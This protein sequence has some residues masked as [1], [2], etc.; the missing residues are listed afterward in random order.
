MPRFSVG[1]H[2]ASS[3]FAPVRKII[4]IDMDAFYAS[5]E[6]RDHPD[7]QGKAIA[8]GGGGRRG[9]ITTASYE[10]RK[11]GVRS[12]MPGFKAK[13]LCPHLIFVPLRFDAYKEASQQIR[14]VFYQYT[15]LV[16]PLSFDE[17]FLDVT[18]NKINE[19]IATYL[20]ERIRKEVYEKTQL[21]CSAGVSYCKFLAK[22]ASDIN[23]PNGLTVIKPAQAEAFLERLPIRKFFGIGKKTAQKMEAMDIRSGRDLKAYSKIEL[24]TRFGKMGRYFYDI[25]RG[26]DNR[27]VQPDRLRKSIGVERTFREDLEGFE[28]IF[29]ELEHIMEKFWERL[30]RVDDFGRTLTLK[31]KTNEFKTLTR[32]I[33]KDYYLRDQDEIMELATMLLDQNSDTFESIRLL[34]LSASNL[35]KEELKTAPQLTFKFDK[36]ADAEDPRDF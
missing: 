23:K 30:T 15:D 11:F 20:A 21:T 7:L 12:A 29:P 18:E 31:V 26:V 5:V 2:K 13:R 10:A 22:V 25:V 19:P 6:Q 35:E 3:N 28:E 1:V 36:T 4:H 33:S 24:A 17:A 34:G 8:V 9:V 16:E 32:S 14:E 27:P